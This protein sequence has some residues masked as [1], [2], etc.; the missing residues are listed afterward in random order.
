[1]PSPSA[2]RPETNSN[3]AERSRLWDHL[4]AGIA[5]VAIRWSALV[6]VLFLA[7]AGLALLYIQEFPIRSAYLELLP[8][9]DPLVVRFRTFE[10]EVASTDVVAVLFTLAFPPES[11]E[12]RVAVLT[13]AADRVLAELRSPDIVVASYRLGTNIPIPPEILF[14]RTLSQEELTRLQN[15]A[16]EVQGRFSPAPM[17]APPV[18]QIQAGLESMDPEVVRRALSALSLTG[19]AALAF[20]QELPRSE[21]PFAEAAAI[22][23]NARQRLAPADAGYPILSR[24]RTRLILQIWPSRRPYESLTYNQR[25]VQAVRDAVARADLGALGV[26]AGLT[27][28]YVTI[29]EVDAVIR[30]DMNLVTLI[31]SVAI[32]SMLMVVL[33]S[34]FL[35][36][37]AMAP[38]LV[39]I[40][41]TMA[42]A[43]FAVGGFNLITVFLPALVLG[44]GI[45]YS[46]HIVARYAEERMAGRGV[47]A[48][49]TTAVRSKGRA[50]LT[51]AVTTSGVF[52]C[53][54]LSH[55]RALWEMGAIM[56]LGILVA[57]ASSLFLT[58]ALVALV[59]TKVHR[60]WPR[61]PS[62]R[63]VRHVRRGVA[64][65]KTVLFWER[66]FARS[67]LF[68]PLYRKFL[69]LRWGVTTV[70][71]LLTGAL[72]YQAS[73]VQF[74]FASPELVPP[75]PS[76]TV[77]AT[78]TREFAGEVWLGESF[79]FF[80]DRFE[81]VRGLAEKLAAHPLVQSAISARDLLPQEILKGE[82]PVWDVPVAD[83]HGAVLDLER[84]L[85]RWN[86]TISQIQD[87]VVGLSLR[88]L[89]AIVAGRAE[90]ARVLSQGVDELVQLLWDMEKV[91]PEKARAVAAGVAADLSE[92]RSFVESLQGLPPEPV[93]LEQILAVLPEGVRTQYRTK[94]GQYVV[95][96]RM[97][98]DIYEGRNLRQFLDWADTLGLER[99]GLPEVTARLE[100]YMKR[101][102]AVSTALAVLIILVLVWRNFP[103]PK[104]TALVV[105]PLAMGYVWMLAGMKLMGIKFNFTNI[106]ISPLLV[107]IGVDSAVHLFHRVE[108]ERRAGGDAVARAAAASTIPVLASSLTTMVAFGALLAA[109]TPGLR[110]LGTSA[111]LG[112]GFTLLW[113]I[114][115][116]PAAAALVLEKTG[117]RE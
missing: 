72:V 59:S 3:P 108:E 83:I 97:G 73:R 49:L 89:L 109:Q 85:E 105:A 56:A 80:V 41:F 16:T 26:T 34:P 82:I 46:I 107:G 78:I 68:H 21:K 54:L 50:C 87:T 33:A 98:R 76:Q 51:A 104:E 92:I 64:A 112:L 38:V 1:M 67:M 18:E 96:A 99:F 19:R 6:V 35:C 17:G 84:A 52:A 9:K 111:L 91:N 24:D 25:V 79:R 37:A 44:L 5:R 114:T 103:R 93:L 66:P 8:Q 14:L 10:E 74:R 70:A 116:L 12:E 58:P 102:F 45:D 113:S 4:F 53:L 13:K 69:G 81:D 39:S 2:R 71:L 110:L 43:K 20:L 101:D 31:S 94:A 60:K 77:L 11:G 75:T 32:L 7:L 30:R 55:S 28:P 29:V 27:G 86:F 62:S 90:L 42:W 115:F 40:L 47:G 95:E 61:E 48:A 106:V 22:V 23:R 36:V 117:A 100:T 63:P 88:E 65:L 57:L 15:I